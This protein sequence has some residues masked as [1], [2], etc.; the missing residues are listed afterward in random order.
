MSGLIEGRSGCPGCDGTGAPGSRGDAGGGTSL[1]EA[2]GGTALGGVLGWRPGLS[3]GSGLI[4]AAV[5]ETGSS[6][7][8]C[9]C[10]AVNMASGI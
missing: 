5:P 1:G 2:G 8:S 9:E 10:I 4:P 7:S 3:G 6:A